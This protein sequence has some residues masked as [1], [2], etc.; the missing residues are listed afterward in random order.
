VN[1][2]D[3]AG[4][5]P[6]GSAGTGASAGTPAHRCGL[7]F[8]SVRLLLRAGEVLRQVGYDVLVVPR[9]IKGCG[10][11][12]LVERHCTAAAIGELAKRSI[13]PAEVLPYQSELEVVDDEVS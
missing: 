13:E 5:V 7:A 10:V 2:A 12:L 11:L 6:A 3:N 8:S 1:C 9:H 4:G